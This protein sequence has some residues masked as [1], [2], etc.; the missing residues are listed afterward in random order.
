MTNLSDSNSSSFDHALEVL[1]QIY[2]KSDVELPFLLVKQ[3]YEIEK[4]HQF[5]EEP[6]VAINKIRALV[7]EFVEKE[8][9]E[10]EDL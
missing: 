1:Q 8:M 7:T 4:N 2:S 9:K 10:Q 3:A 5:D 6:E